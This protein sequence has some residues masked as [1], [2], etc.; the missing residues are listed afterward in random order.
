MKKRKYIT[1]YIVLP[2]VTTVLVSLLLEMLVGQIPVA[3]LKEN[4]Q[5]SALFYMISGLHPQEGENAVYTRKDYYADTVLLNLICSRNEKYPVKNLILAPYYDHASMDAAE[6]YMA[7]AFSEAEANTY[8]FR[9]WHGSMIWLNPLL[10]LMDVEGIFKLYKVLTIGLLIFI[11]IWCVARKR[12]EVGISFGV[13]FLIIEGWETVSCLEYGNTMLLLLV[14]TVVY[15]LQREKSVANLFRLSVINGVLTCFID[16]LTI[17][18]LVFTIPT[19]M[20]ILLQMQDDKDPSNWI[21]N[22]SML[23]GV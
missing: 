21:C 9:Y 23:G 3:T 7:V 18:T 8:Y 22:N 13:A 14:L 16:Y 2:F 4:A 12:W 10:C 6:D 5:K 1:Q 15:L 20:W 11:I 19:G 17:E